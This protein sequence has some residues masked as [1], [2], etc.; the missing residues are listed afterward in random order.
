MSYS[1]WQPQ[2]TMNLEQQKLSELLGPLK[3]TNN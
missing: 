3:E 2:L 1:L